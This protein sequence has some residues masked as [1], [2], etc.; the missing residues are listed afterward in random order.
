MRTLCIILFTF[1]NTS[2]HSKLVPKSRTP[3][4]RKSFAFQ[5]TSVVNC[6]AING[7]SN[8]TAAPDRMMISLLFFT[9]FSFD[10]ESIAKSNFAAKFS[11]RRIRV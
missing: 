5:S 4:I 8:K 1:L 7:M 3:I 9:V 2:S 6:I 11:P 10:Y